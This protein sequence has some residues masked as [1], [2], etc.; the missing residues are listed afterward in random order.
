[1]LKKTITFEDFDG[2]TRSG[3]FYF[4]LTQS[5]LQRYYFEHGNQGLIEYL[6]N[7][8]LTK[9][10]KALMDFISEMIAITYGVKSEDGLRF[11]KDPVRTREFTQ[12]NAYDV[13]YRELLSEE[14]AISDFLTGCFP[15]NAA[16]VGNISKDDIAKYMYGEMS[17]DEL[18]SS[19]KK[20][21]LVQN[22]TNNDSRS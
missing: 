9:D 11:I 1:M 10:A 2:N 19:K 6:K 12:T 7:V 4:N 17:L 13:L 16:S 5:E 8:V 15:K 18:L 20:M 14:S 21:E 22:A 3:D